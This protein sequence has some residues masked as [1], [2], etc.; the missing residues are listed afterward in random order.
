MDM[1]MKNVGADI[2]GE[3]E[4]RTRVS[5][6][7]PEESRR[8]PSAD[9]HCTPVTSSALTFGDILLQNRFSFA[10]HARKATLIIHFQICTIVSEFSHQEARGRFRNIPIQIAMATMSAVHAL[11]RETGTKKTPLKRP[12]VQTKHSRSNSAGRNISYFSKINFQERIG[13]GDRGTTLQ[14]TTEFMRVH[15]NFSQKLLKI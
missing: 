12:S 3:G 8:E 14:F 7:I 5:R 1:R 9:S 10:P 6:V 4:R 2:G 15:F 13:I 11:E